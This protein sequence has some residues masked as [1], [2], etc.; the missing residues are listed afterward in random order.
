MAK[1]KYIETPDKMEIWKEIE[2]YHGY[3][4]SNLGNVRSFRKR[5]SKELYDKPHLIK[6]GK[7]GRDGSYLHFYASN[8]IGRVRLSVHRCV[9]NAF[10][11][12]QNN[13]PEV[14]HKD[15]NGHNNHVD[16]LE[17]VSASENQLH[18]RGGCKFSPSVGIDRNTFRVCFRRNGKRTSKNFK[19]KKVATA[20]SNSIYEWQDQ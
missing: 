19:T 8:E 14:N 9:A 20:F 18:A 10:I 13:K 16:N 15:K 17:W 7:T 4:V 2:G 3:E 6:L 5:N 11:Q 1:K 12:N